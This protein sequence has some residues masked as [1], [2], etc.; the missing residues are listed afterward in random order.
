MTH[1]ASFSFV[2][3]LPCCFLFF[4]P[5]QVL[6]GPSPVR[7]PPRILPKLASVRTPFLLGH[8]R[9]CNTVPLCRHCMVVTSPWYLLTAIRSQ[10]TFS[11]LRVS[12]IPECDPRKAPYLLKL[13][14]PHCKDNSAQAMLL[15]SESWGGKQ[16][17]DLYGLK[18]SLNVSYHYC[19]MR[20]LSSV[21]SEA[22]PFPSFPHGSYLVPVRLQAN[23][24]YQVKNK[25][26]NPLVYQNYGE[27]L[28]ILHQLWALCESKSETSSLEKQPGKGVGA[29]HSLSLQGK[30]LP[31]NWGWVE[32]GSQG[33][34]FLLAW[35][36]V[37]EGEWTREHH[38]LP[39]THS[40]YL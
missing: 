18:S 10:N 35:A 25:S 4:S 14:C 8:P 17:T 2:L 33:T 19:S 7:T 9:C 13:H 27:I 11:M 21:L 31:A 38:W 6:L 32:C 5:W 23:I 22:T 40:G 24:R 36:N 29:M 3:V 30:S 34:S 16:G 12:H 1:L 26:M 37:A 20:F 15:P 39:A 28:N